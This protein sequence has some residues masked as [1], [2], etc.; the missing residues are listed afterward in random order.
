MRLSW[1][2]TRATPTACSPA[3]S[4][5]GVRKAGA[6]AVVVGICPTP[7]VAMYQVWRGATAAF[8]VTASH[9]FRDQNGIKIFHG[10]HALKLFPDDDRALT[11]RV[12]DLDYAA[13]VAPL[14]PDAAAS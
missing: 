7:G 4:V 3:R 6:T 12:L 13:D 5:R 10:P 9:N 11:R 14:D 1:G 8:M 2:G